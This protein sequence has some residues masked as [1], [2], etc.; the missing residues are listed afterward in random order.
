MPLSALSKNRHVATVTLSICLQ[1]YRSHAQFSRIFREAGYISVKIPILETRTDAST[2]RPGRP[3]PAEQQKGV[4]RDNHRS[5][6]CNRAGEQQIRHH[7]RGLHAPGAHRNP[8]ARRQRQAA[9]LGAAGC[10]TRTRIP[11]AEP[12]GTGGRLRAAGHRPPR[13]RPDQRAGAPGPPGRLPLQPRTGGLPG[14]RRPVPGRRTTGCSPPTATPSPSWPGRRPG[15]GAWP[16]PRA[17]GTAATTRTQYKVSHQSTPLATQLLHAV[18]VAHAAKLRG[19]DTVVLAMC[20][21]GATSEGDFHE[22]LNFA[23]VFHLPVVFFVQNNQY[24]ISVP[25]SQ[26]TVAPSLAH[27][28]IGYGMPGERVDGNDLAALLAVLGRAVAPGPRGRR[29]AAGRG[30]HL[31]DAGAHQR[32]RRHPLPRRR[33]GRR[34]GSPRTRSPGCAPT[35]ADAGLL[36]RGTPRHGSPPGRGGRHDPARRHELGKRPG[37]GRPLRPRLREPHHRSWREQAALLADE[38]AREEDAK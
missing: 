10:R 4:N 35:C 21:D 2:D 37:P 17:T 25:L 36:R 19:E 30:P 5:T 28:A 7:P 20:G 33:R 14:R 12:Q 32:R 31:P 26:Q 3:R 8:H 15:G 24:A 1:E 11:A 6:R 18:G 13:Q 27:K 34:A 38:L 22:A 23:A 9:P 16:L 29:P